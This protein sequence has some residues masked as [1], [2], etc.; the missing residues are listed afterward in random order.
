MKPIS[1]ILSLDA[2]RAAYAK[3]GMEPRAAI[4]I[5]PLCGVPLLDGYASAWCGCPASAV[6][7]AMGVRPVD[8]D[9][10][11]DQVDFLAETFGVEPRL[12]RAFTEGV[13][14]RD[15]GG[16]DDDEMVA[17]AHGRTVREALGL[18]KA[19]K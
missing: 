11:G 16:H 18:G 4:F 17:Y 13:D 5:E 1:E 12:V 2:I 10:A 9:E 3:T 15:F 14:R 19:G 7:V 6:A 8:I